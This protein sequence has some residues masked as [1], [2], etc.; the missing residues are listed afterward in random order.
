MDPLNSKKRIL[1]TGGC[2]FVGRHLAKR[3]SEDGSNELTIVDDLSAGLKPEHWAEHLRCK[4]H[5]VVYQDCIDFFHSNKEYFDVVFHCAAVVGGRVTIEEQPLQVAKDLAIDAELF[6]WAAITKPGKIVYMSSSA[7][8]PIRFQQKSGHRALSEDLVDVKN[9]K[10]DMPDMSYGWAKLTGEYLSHLAVQKYGFRVAVYRPFSGYGEDQDPSYPVPALMRRIVD[11]E[12]P[13]QVWG[14]GTQMRDFVYIEDCIDCI[15]N[16]YERIDDASPLNI[17]SGTPT[18][19]LDL[20]KLA[21]EIAGLEY[22]VKPMSDKPV[23]VYARYADTV[24][25]TAFGFRPRTTLR[26]GLG[27]VIHHLAIHTQ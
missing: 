9:G 6:G 14:D 12:T 26:D 23:G 4:P 24:K 3:L 22:Q 27:R 13:I 5:A 11:R 10:I 17:G 20:I 8:Y 7:V 15:L 16:T 2:G 18:S 25:Q 19:F 21:S 1:I